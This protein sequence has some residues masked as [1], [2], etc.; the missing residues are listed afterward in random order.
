ML[1]DAGLN[2]LPS[3]EK[4]V[5]FG[6]NNEPIVIE[7]LTKYFN[8]PIQKT[9][10][11]FC[12]Y[13]AYSN[14]TKYEIKSRRCRYETYST[15]IIPT[16]KVKENENDKVVF[17]FHFTNG[18]YYIVYNKELF[19]TFE[20]KEYTYFR[21]GGSNVPVKHYSIPIEHLIKIDI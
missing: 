8:E 14:N 17:V 7:K 1:Y 11:K 10:N 5:V 9:K 16:H 13:D 19:A 12:Y 3:L 4:D 18:L 15:T 6:L 20:I 21:S 2:L